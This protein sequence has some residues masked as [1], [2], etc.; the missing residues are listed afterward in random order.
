MERAQAKQVVARRFQF[1]SPRPDHGR[2][3]RLP[4]DAVNLVLGDH[5]H[6]GAFPFREGVK[7]DVTVSL[8]F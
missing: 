3:V 5:W 4:L 6:G 1:H 8:D 2:Q 7:P